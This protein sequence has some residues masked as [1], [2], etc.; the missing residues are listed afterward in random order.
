MN[1]SNSEKFTVEDN[2]F[3]NNVSCLPCPYGGDCNVGFIT[4]RPKF[5]GYKYDGEYYFQRCPEGYCCDGESV[6][7]K[8]FDT[9]SSARRGT[10]CGRCSHGY[11]ESILST[12]CVKDSLCDDYWVYPLYVIGALM[13]ILYYSYKSE[14][15]T[16]GVTIFKLVISKC[17][18]KEEE[19]APENQPDAQKIDSVSKAVSN[20]TIDT[21]MTGRS[22]HPSP[23]VI[24]RSRTPSVTSVN[25]NALPPEPMNSKAKAAMKIDVQW[26]TLLTKISHL[27][28]TDRRRLLAEREESEGVDRGYLGIITYYAQA[29]ALMRVA[30]EFSQLRTSGVM[31]TIEEYTVKYLD[32]DVYEVDLEL[33]PFP[34]IDALFKALIRTIFV[35]SIYFLW[36]ILFLIVCTVKALCDGQKRPAKIAKGFYLKLIEGLVEIIKY[37]YSS[38]A[39]SNFS[40]LTCIFIGNSFVWK[41]D[42]TVTCFQKWQGFAALGLLFYTIPFS[43]SLAMGSKLLK[44]GKISSH[45]FLFSCILPLP[46]CLLWFLLYICKWRHSSQKGAKASQPLELTE[47]TEV[48]LDVLQAPYRNDDETVITFTS[49]PFSNQDNKK[50]SKAKSRLSQLSSAVYWEGIMEFRRLVLNALTLVNNDIIRLTLISTTCLLILLHHLYVKPFKLSRSNTAETFSLSFLLIISVMNTIKAAFSE[51]G[52]IPDGPNEALLLFFQRADNVFLFLLI[53]FILGIEMY[54][55]FKERRQKKNL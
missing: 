13:Y 39:G 47:T 26:G 31:D 8:T 25:E 2:L 37:T 30:V 50:Q 23:G 16:L 27:D 54:F 6:P 51:N 44:E 32:F 12:N 41:L 34:G 24:I 40:L 11:S 21:L 17:E 18:R 52:V 7:C 15:A 29:S 5:W 42:G 55:F 45:H 35:L 33:C 36:M 4:S 1:F 3:G 46:F 43:F 22:P 20:R 10:L 28:T 38:L 49:F 19:S 14:L 48:I 53:S 9:C